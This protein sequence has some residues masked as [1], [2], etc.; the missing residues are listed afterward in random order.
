MFYLNPFKQAVLFAFALTISG[1]VLA[2]DT[3]LTSPVNQTVLIELYTSEGCS[4]C[5]PAEKHLNSYT[6]NPDL[7]KSYI[8]LTF[9]VDYWD[10][11][12]WKDRFAKPQY[13]TRQRQYARMHR[14]SSVY[15]PAFFVNG[16]SWRPG[17]FTGRIPDKRTHPVGTLELQLLKNRII[18]TFK[19]VQET[20][21]RLELNLAILGMG[22]SSSIEAGENSGRQSRHD[23]VVLAHEQY[24]AD[25]MTWDTAWPNYDA[26]GS[27]QQ[28]LVAW[29]SEKGDPTP[30]QAVGG[31]IPSQFRQ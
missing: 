19:P 25:T 31:Y 20:S 13:G 24:T 17:L 18:S 21:G 10:Y 8:P 15:T 16:Q 26:A 5:P 27:T 4:S 3:V 28:A 2:D 22:I 30:I 6:D 7:W 29:I 11:I 9:H 12:G 23:F 1:T 14:V